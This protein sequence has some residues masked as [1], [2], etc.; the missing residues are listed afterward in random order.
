MNFDPPYRRSEKLVC[1]M[2]GCDNWTPNRVYR[3]IRQCTRYVC[4]EH[5]T[6]VTL[7]WHRRLWMKVFRRADLRAFDHSENYRRMY[8]ELSG[9]GIDAGDVMERR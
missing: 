1:A 7:A 5:V 6:R 9:S 8:G 4:P 3:G 2:D